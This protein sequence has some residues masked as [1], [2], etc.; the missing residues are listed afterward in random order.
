M[1]KKRMV[2]D[3]TTGERTAMVTT[4]QTGRAEWTVSREWQD[5]KDKA[6]EKAQAHDAELAAFRRAIDV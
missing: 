2:T 5:D 1:I 4:N 6:V 3:P